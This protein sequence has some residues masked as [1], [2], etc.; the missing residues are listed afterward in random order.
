M[1]GRS[2]ECLAFIVEVEYHVL[3]V[4]EDGHCGCSVDNLHPFWP[5][6]ALTWI[7]LVKVAYIFWSFVSDVK[8]NRF[9]NL[10]YLQSKEN[11]TKAKKPTD[12]RAPVIV[13]FVSE[14]NCK[15]T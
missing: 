5:I 13:L 9:E 8:N 12:T 15:G 1:L 10:S 14:K 11:N 3:H 6:L 4:G 7:G 2:I